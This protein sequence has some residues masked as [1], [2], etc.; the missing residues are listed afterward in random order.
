ML[1]QS[2]SAI[3]T[4]PQTSSEG[5]TSSYRRTSRYEPDVER[6]TSK[7]DEFLPSIP[8]DPSAIARKIREG[9]SER[10]EI[11]ICL[12]AAVA[13]TSEVE[14]AEEDQLIVEFSAKSS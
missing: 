14:G 7:A 5:R 12:R 2:F 11:N 9:S 4:A 3:Q 10:I 6:H 1:L 13:S 8:A